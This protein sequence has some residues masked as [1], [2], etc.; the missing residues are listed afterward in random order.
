[1][2]DKVGIA[3]SMILPPDFLSFSLSFLILSPPPPPLL[4]P[5]SSKWVSRELGGYDYE[6]GEKFP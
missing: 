2:K 5:S 3:G 4:S 1:M 6:G